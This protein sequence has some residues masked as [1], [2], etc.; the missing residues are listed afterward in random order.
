MENNFNNNSALSKLKSVV[1]NIN[2]FSN[3]N[4]GT[5]VSNVNDTKIKELP[6]KLVK[7][8]AK[9]NRIVKDVS[10]FKKN[11]IEHTGVHEN[12]DFTDK[13]LVKEFTYTTMYDNAYKFFQLDNGLYEKRYLQ[14]V[15][16]IGLVYKVHNDATNGYDH[17]LYIGVARHATDEQ[18]KM[19][20]LNEGIEYAKSYAMTSPDA[21]IKVSRAFNREAFYLIC[22]GLVEGMR[23]KPMKV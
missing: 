1:N 20:K 17:I 5:C 18:I 12:H 15:T 16:I 21:I 3:C 2:N 6:D 23:L 8:Y 19:S 14:P 4:P 13:K 9:T 11:V 22:D 7:E 10:E